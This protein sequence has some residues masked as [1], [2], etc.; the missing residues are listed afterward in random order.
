MSIE[1]ENDQS[2]SRFA[3][4]PATRAD[5]G[6][7]ARFRLHGTTGSRER[8]WYYGILKS[9]SRISPFAYRGPMVCECDSWDVCEIQY[10]PNEEP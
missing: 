6:S 1:N 7:V 10:D 2:Q 5:I 8:D 3:W 4:R 9:I